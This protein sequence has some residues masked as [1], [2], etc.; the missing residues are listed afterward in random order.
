MKIS[1]CLNLI[2]W[3]M[4]A[5]RGIHFDAVRAKLLLI[6]VRLEQF[7]YQNTHK[8]P[9]PLSLFIWFLCR[10]LGSVFQWFLCN[11]LI[12]GSVELG[13]GLRLP[14]PQNI[15]IV[16]YAKIGE[17]CLIYQNVTIA[18]NGFYGMANRD[19]SPKVGDCVLIGSGAIIIGNVT[20][21]SRTSI[22]AGSVVTKSVP[23]NSIVRSPQP[24]ITQFEVQPTAVEPGSEQ[25][26]KDFYSIWR[27]QT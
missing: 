6:E 8:H 10:G 24:N 5:N 26:M 2:H 11:A 4:R 14:H 17:F 12:A 7:I 19:L 25:H 18:W 21:G 1:E 16:Q 22:G 20:I 23:D 27:H 13:R 15:V 9:N 3:D